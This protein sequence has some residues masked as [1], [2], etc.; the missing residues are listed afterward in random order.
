[1]PVLATGPHLIRP[2]PGQ[3]TTMRIHIDQAQADKT[4]EAQLKALAAQLRC[5]DGEEGI[6]LGQIMNMSNLSAVMHGLAHLP[7]RAHDSILELGYGNGGLLGYILS[8]AEDL[9]YTGVEISS[10]MHQQAVSLNQPYIDANLAQYLLYDGISLPLSGPR[11]DKVLT[12]NTLY[13]WPEPFK[14]LESICRVLKPGGLFCLTF[15]DKT[16]MQALPYT[17]Y[18]FRL[19]GAAE[20][21]ALFD[22]LPLQLVEE[23]H[24][25]DKCISKT[26]ILVEREIVSLVFQKQA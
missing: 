12:V 25:K 26:R 2:F 9:H 1:M 10:T 16:F 23:A 20:A 24:K 18:G 5:P 21:K 7:V 14:L 6:K 15:C 8:L 19:Y 13:F 3:R 17:S 22:G 4:M 11:F